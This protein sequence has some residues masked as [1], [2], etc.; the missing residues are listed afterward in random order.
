MTS[1]KDS[2]IQLIW[3]S[4]LL[5]VGLYLIGLTASCVA[6]SSQE[7]FD[8]SSETHEAKNA[9]ASTPNYQVIT[10]EQAR[11]KWT[12]TEGRPLIIHEI[13][14]GKSRKQPSDSNLM[15]TGG[16]LIEVQN[17][18]DKSITNARFMLVP[19]S[20]ATFDMLPGMYLGLGND[21]SY[22]TRI[23]SPLAPGQHFTIIINQA[24]FEPWRNPKQLLRGA[25]CAAEDMYFQLGMIN[26][27]FADGSEWKPADYRAN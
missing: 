18:S 14:R 8:Q 12:F 6:P 27:K 17:I 5:V 26:V 1:L 11:V 15:D 2:L 13:K 3:R 9:D 19:P 21:E 7:A 23:K 24:R 4:F 16:L 10:F 20:C 22:M 25:K